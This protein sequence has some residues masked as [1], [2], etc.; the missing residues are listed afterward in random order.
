MWLNVLL[1]NDIICILFIFHILLSKY[2]VV[3]ITISREPQSIF[4]IGCI[5][6][7]PYVSNLSIN[8]L[9]MEEIHTPGRFL[10]QWSYWI[11][12][13][14]RKRLIRRWNSMARYNN[15]WHCFFVRNTHF[16]Y[17]LGSLL[18]FYIIIYFFF[19]PS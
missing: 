7:N 6:I 2:F 3:V 13:M 9:W 8:Y 10:W 4:D 17:H 11:L 5:I 1:F 16:S 18:I 19:F 15:F 12:R 14:F